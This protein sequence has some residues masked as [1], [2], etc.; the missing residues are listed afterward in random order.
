LF[1]SVSFVIR[2]NRFSLQS[3]RLHALFG[4]LAAATRLA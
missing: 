1:N 2:H 4:G 3:N